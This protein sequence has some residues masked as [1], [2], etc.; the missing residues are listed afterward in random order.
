MRVNVQ[1]PLVVD[2][3]CR[4]ANYT[5]FVSWLY[6]FIVTKRVN[7]DQRVQTQTTH[8]NYEPTKYFYETVYR[9]LPLVENVGNTISVT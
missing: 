8:T 9:L 5:D 4:Q 7:I 2:H 6:Y 1:K 3:L